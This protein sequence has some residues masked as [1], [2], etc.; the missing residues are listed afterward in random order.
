MRAERLARNVFWKRLLMVNVVFIGEPGAGDGEWALVDA[1]LPLSADAIEREAKRLGYRGAPCG[2]FITHAHFDH[3]GAVR[4]LS[5]RWS[6]PVYAQERELPHLTGR[7]A[8]P[9]PDPSVGGGW[10]SRLSILYPTKAIDLG[11]AARALPADGTVPGLPDWRWIATPGHTDGHLSLFRESD[12]TLIGGDAF[13][14]VQQESLG[15]VL[16]QRSAVHGPPAYL[17]TDWE[18]AYRS[19]LAIRDLRP[20]AAVPGHGLPIVGE[21]DCG[22]YFELLCDHFHDIAVPK[23]SKFL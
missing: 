20:H 17:T 16:T 2:I 12:R 14:T 10:M 15:A 19:T 9:T 3:V 21:F 22:A 1:G 23:Q 6:A 5:R 11:E 7:A 4:E 18:A 8:Y 13:A